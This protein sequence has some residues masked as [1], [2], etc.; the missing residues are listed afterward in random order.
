MSQHLRLYLIYEVLGLVFR[1]YGGFIFSALVLNFKC[2][3]KLSILEN[4]PSQSCDYGYGDFI[5]KHLF[6]V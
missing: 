2:S 5:H 4:G 1:F 3:V 6:E